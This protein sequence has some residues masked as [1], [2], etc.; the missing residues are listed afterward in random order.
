MADTGT[1]NEI[2]LFTAKLP[3]TVYSIQQGLNNIE[4]Y[5]RGL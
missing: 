4:E 5:Y 2:N 3:S 1:Q